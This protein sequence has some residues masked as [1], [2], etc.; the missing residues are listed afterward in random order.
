MRVEAALESTYQAITEYSELHDPKASRPA[1]VFDP[2]NS[3]V[4]IK[5][6]K[7]SQVRHLLVLLCC[8]CAA[9]A[10]PFSFMQQSLINLWLAGDKH[11][12]DLCAM[13]TH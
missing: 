6:V 8:C 10:V 7:G 9:A 1:L 2:V 11:C 5:L 3:A 4:W 13:Q 12:L